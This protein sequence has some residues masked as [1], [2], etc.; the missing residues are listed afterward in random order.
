MSGVTTSLRFPGQLN[1]DLRKLAVNMVPFHRSEC[2]QI[3]IIFSIN[4]P[5]LD[6]TSSC[7]GLLRS[8][9]EAHNSTG[10]NVFAARINAP[11]GGCSDYAATS[12]KAL[13]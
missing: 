4:S 13:R 5:H 1:A 12:T 7:L 3:F 8:H 11:V 10:K 2:Q 9:P 6:S